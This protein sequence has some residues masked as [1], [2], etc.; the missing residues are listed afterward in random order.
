MLINVNKVYKDE[1]GVEAGLEELEDMEIAV[2]FWGVVLS[3]LDLQCR[4]KSKAHPPGVDEGG[5]S[6]RAS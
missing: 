1:G 2:F 5:S 3:A 4:S 6:S